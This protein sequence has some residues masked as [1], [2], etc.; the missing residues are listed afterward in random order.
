LPALAEL[1]QQAAA[2]LRRDAARR[3]HG[4]GKLARGGFA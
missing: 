2:N 4:H 3:P 1:P